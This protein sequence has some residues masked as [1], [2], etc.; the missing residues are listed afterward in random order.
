M[1]N[2]VVFV[3]LLL[4]LLNGIIAWPI[5]LVAAVVWLVFL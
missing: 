3:V 1:T 4:L 5:A 2:A